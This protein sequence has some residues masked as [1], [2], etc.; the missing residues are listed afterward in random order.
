MHHLSLRLALSVSTLLLAAFRP[1]D[2]HAV[3]AGEGSFSI[4]GNKMQ[5][6]VKSERMALYATNFTVG[7]SER[8]DCLGPSNANLLICSFGNEGMQIHGEVFS[9]VGLTLVSPAGIF[10][11]PMAEIQALQNFTAVGG[12]I[13]TND[14]MQG[15]LHFTHLDGDIL[16]KGSLISKGLALFVG[17]SIENLGEIAA[18]TL[19]WA[20][21]GS[22]YLGSESEHIRVKV[23]HGKEVDKAD[24]P[25]VNHGMLKAQ[26][27]IIFRSGDPYTQALLQGSEGSMEADLVS[28]DTHG[29]VRLSGAIDADRIE[30]SGLRDLTLSHIKAPTKSQW[31]LEASE[32]I[33]WG[34][35]KAHSIEGSLK[36][37]AT[38]E[39]VDVEKIDLKM[40]KGRLT[41]LDLKA[42]SFA[43]DAK[44]WQIGGS[45]D[46][47]SG[48]D[49]SQLPIQLTG[50]IK[51]AQQISSQGKISLGRVDA[52]SRSFD[53]N[54]D[55]IHLNGN[56]ESAKKIRFLAPTLGNNR[57][58]SAHDMVF[59]G[60]YTIQTE[61]ELIAN[62]SILFKGMVNSPN[63]SYLKIQAN[64][65]VK[66]DQGFG[67]DS[68]PLGSLTFSSVDN[69]DVRGGLCADYLIQLS[70]KGETHISEGIRAERGVH[71]CTSGNIRVD[72]KID[73]RAS[74]L[75]PLPK[76]GN[77]GG[78]LYIHSKRG[79]VIVHDIDTSGAPALSVG[80]DAGS[81]TLLQTDL[82][83]PSSEGTHTP[84]GQLRLLGKEYLA[85]GG[86]GQRRGG[87]GQ[88]N[89][90][91]STLEFPDRASILSNANI[92]IAGGD[93]TL[94]FNT[95]AGF[96]ENLHLK[97]SGN[98]YATDILVFGDL[99][100][101]AKDLF[102]YPHS[103]GKVR[104]SSGDIVGS[105]PTQMV[106]LGSIDSRVGKI[107]YAPAAG[108]QSHPIQNYAFSYGMI[109]E[110]KLGIVDMLTLE[111]GSMVSPPG[112]S[113]LQTMTPAAALIAPFPKLLG[114]PIEPPKL[115]NTSAATINVLAQMIEESIAKYAPEDLPVWQE[116]RRE[117]LASHENPAS[118]PIARYQHRL[119]YSLFEPARFVNSLGR[120]DKGRLALQFITQVN[121]LKEA[122]QE[123]K[124]KQKERL[125]SWLT[126][127]TQPQEVTKSRWQQIC[128]VARAQLKRNK[129]RR[130]IDASKPIFPMHSGGK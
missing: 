63:R 112:R 49:A 85:L 122:L 18:D 43:V 87:D 50:P 31:F 28:I 69:L 21:G 110:R 124:T 68:H 125:I 75:K 44:G 23:S 58:I 104:L 64:G 12:R 10:F 15:N 93:L 88:I 57:R 4:D 65:D 86:G 77:Q 51:T 109:P 39:G 3:A 22:V 40:P 19:I 55:R 74:K 2:D 91:N 26:G 53:V 101:A 41:T 105:G 36:G 13:D 126:S 116:I 73:T 107:H 94:G 111:D 11:G 37:D 66:A 25:L 128:D 67:R 52:N 54:A 123:H 16:N 120:S 89:I 118:L 60:P 20:S 45:V 32:I 47:H 84:L 14:F 56:I 121:R 7:K 103:K 119:R 34:P 80:G 61:N 46:V 106:V 48:F 33:G 27:R 95:S 82:L 108:Y 71:L 114:F 92:R 72:G 117:V 98:L 90:G 78:D 127:F 81:I 59:Q 79:S 99:S 35:F 113:Y 5:V 97:L 9:Q 1:L 129:K 6:N 38:F 24:V 62:G 30:L 42:Q 76:K 102:V 70:G 130:K 17:R 115:K 83:K 100:I 8:L 29:N 96:S